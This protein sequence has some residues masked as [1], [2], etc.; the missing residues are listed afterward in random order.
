M[1]INITDIKTY[2]VICRPSALILNYIY[3]YMYI[4]IYTFYIAMYSQNHPNKLKRQ[5]RRN[6]MNTGTKD[7]HCETCKSSFHTKFDLN[8]HM[9]QHR[10]VLCIMSCD[11]M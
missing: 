2:K 8:G 5:D 11:T 4:Y 7:F 10:Q 6:S 1:H 3:I 9:S